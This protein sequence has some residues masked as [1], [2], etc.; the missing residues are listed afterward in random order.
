MS[1]G[2]LAAVVG[3]EELVD[4]L[5]AHDDV[6]VRRA[7]ARGC[8]LAASERLDQVALSRLGHARS[9]GE[10]GAWLEVA[11]MRGLASSAEMA[12]VAST[13]P[14]VVA[15]ALRCLRQPIPSMSSTVDRLAEHP[16][17]QVREAALGVALAW[18][19]PRAFAICEAQA[20]DDGQVAPLA[21]V[22]YGILGGATAHARLVRSAA[23]EERRPH[24]FRALGFTGSPGLV[25]ALISG[26]GSKSPLEAKLAAQAIVAITGLDLR[27]DRFAARPP[28]RADSLPPLEED[29]LDADLVPQ[30]E[31]ALPQPNIEAISAWWKE[32]EGEL[33]SSPRLVFGAPWSPG[34]LLWAL[35]NG[36]LGLRRGWALAAHLWSGGRFWLDTEALS[37]VQRNQLAVARGE[38]SHWPGP[39]WAPERRG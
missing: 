13:E 23:S 31:D 34:G 15:A 5:F 10:V 14:D 38:I 4:E 6:G 21:M 19:T 16:D 9:P 36:P 27:T 8:S 32:K 11:G 17:P 2:L 12:L 30:P 29:D 24:V 26:L 33:K 25:P 35:E 1:L 20:L 7:A 22:A 37:T 3:V 39:A 28:P 18:G